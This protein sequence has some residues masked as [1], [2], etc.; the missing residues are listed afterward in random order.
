[1]KSKDGLLS[2]CLNGFAA[3]EKKP[4]PGGIRL[5]AVRYRGARV[6]YSKRGF[7]LSR[8]AILPPSPLY[9]VLPEPGGQGLRTAAGDVVDDLVDRLVVGGDQA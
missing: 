2:F 8:Y 4:N 7:W 1:M 9:G 5:F 3:N 6:C